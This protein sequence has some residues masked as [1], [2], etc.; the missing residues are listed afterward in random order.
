[1]ADIFRRG[2]DAHCSVGGAKCQCCNRFSGIGEK[3]KLRRIVRREL[4][5]QF[6][7]DMEGELRG[8]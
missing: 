7:K 5:Q 4:K 2:M 1:V 8:A 6:R 3:P